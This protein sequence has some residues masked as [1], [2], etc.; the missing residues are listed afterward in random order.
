MA[1]LTGNNIEQ[2]KSGNGAL[3]IDYLSL[4]EDKETAKI[5]LLYNSV[6]DIEGIVVHRVKVGEWELPVNCLLEEGA[7]IDDC[8]FCR[9][10]YPKQARIY[11]PVFDEGD[12]KFKF[13][14]RPNS[15]YS[16]L[17]GQVART[18]NTVSQV[19]EIERSGKRGSNRPG[20]AFYPQGQPDGTTIDDILDDCG[21]DKM[22]DPVGTKILDKS[23]DDMEYYIRNGEFPS[24][25]EAPVRRRGREEDTEPA[26]RRRG[27]SGDRF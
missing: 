26:P 5:R 27:R 22:P 14:D 10:N 8:P 7:P 16:Q 12:Y 1:K 13:W 21:Y 20:Y 4:K 3:K 2:F 24:S 9:E 23:A 15:F 25:E 11:I 18:P 6:D 19:F 17:S